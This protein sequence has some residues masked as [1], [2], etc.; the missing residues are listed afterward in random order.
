MSLISVTYCF[1]MINH[2][3]GKVQF[4]GHVLLL[5]EIKFYWDI[6]TPI[7]LHIISGCFYAITLEL[8]N[9][10]RDQLVPGVLNTCH[11]TLTHT[12]VVSHVLSHFFLLPQN[13]Q[14]NYHQQ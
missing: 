1:P 11:P 10:P 4:V 8:A 6:T 5:S 7:R 12:K 2:R 3:S 14:F 13:L 9:L